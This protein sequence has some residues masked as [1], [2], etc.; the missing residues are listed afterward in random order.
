MTK[1]LKYRF[2][3]LK[4]AFSDSIKNINSNNF[5]DSIQNIKIFLDFMRQKLHLDCFTYI[6]EELFTGLLDFMLN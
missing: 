1:K 3:C 4:N 6:K 2:I 5:I